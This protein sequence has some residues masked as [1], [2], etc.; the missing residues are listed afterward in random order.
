[1][2]NTGLLQIR[3]SKPIVGFPDDLKKKVD[4]NAKGYVEKNGKTEPDIN[5]EPWI[6]PLI[7]LKIIA[8]EDTRMAD[9]KYNWTLAAYEDTLLDI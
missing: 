9:L 3:F 6:V 5:A 8:S 1:M 7:Q 4:R 2:T